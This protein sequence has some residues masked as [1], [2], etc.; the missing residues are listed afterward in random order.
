M[1]SPPTASSLVRMFKLKERGR[2][3]GR[4][5]KP[6]PTQPTLDNVEME[7]KAYCDDLF[8]SHCDEYHGH[9]AAL[10][11]GER[12][13]PGDRGGDATVKDFSNE[14]QDLLADERPELIQLAREA[15]NATSEV[16]RFKRKHNR[17]ADADFPES[18]LWH[19][20]IIIGLV[21]V[22]TFING[23][24][25]GA[26]VEGGTLEG[27]SYAALISVLNVIVLG[28]LL[29]LAARQVR[30]RSVIRR[31]VGWTGILLTVVIA[32]LWN[33][34]VAHYREALLPD[35]PAPPGTEESAQAESCW[36]GESPEDADQ[37]AWCLFKE[38]LFG[39][40]GFYSYLLLF[41]GIAMFFGGAVDW[42]K[43]DDPY[44][45]YGKRE[46]TRR[47]R[48]R[49]LQDDRHELIEKLKAIHDEGGRRLQNDFRDPVEIRRLAVRDHE[50]LKVIHNNLARFAND[51]EKGC[52]GAFTVYRTA[53]R[54]VRSDKEPEIWKMPWNAEWVL[55]APPKS[56]TLKSEE[57]TD[58]R[59]RDLNEALAFRLQALRKYHDK[60]VKTVDELTD[61]D[62]HDQ[63]VPT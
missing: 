32:L 4:E 30:H 48:V 25:F 57:E 26:N 7:V 44:P 56:P 38:S 16:N 12:P 40:N 20:G 18:R 22:E 41:I 29:A 60:C 23:L 46:R 58:K 21:V 51:L 36:Y 59:S 34:L 31:S 28:W 24:F 13:L 54:E 62:V 3:R 9:R 10:E 43:T 15:Q 45:G 35:Y 53:N 55:P 33:F 52:R 14:L 39:L 63:A 49:Q 17:K 11:D 6:R 47:K 27:M 8:R 50:K 42:F 2:E 1:D 19:W 61:L 37:E 5:G